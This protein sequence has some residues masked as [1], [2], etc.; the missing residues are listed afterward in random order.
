MVEQGCDRNWNIRDL[1]G[2]LMGAREEQPGARDIIWASEL[3]KPYIDRWLQMRGVPY[4]NPPEGKDLMAFF[5]GLQIEA[6][7]EQMLVRCGLAFRSQESVRIEIEDCLPVVGKADL[8]LEVRDWES[9]LALRE[10]D[11]LEGG[12][13][14]GHERGRRRALV[15]LLSRWQERCP[16]GLQATVF[17]VKSLNSAAF[18]YHR[19]SEGLSNAYPHHRL[20]LYTYLKGLGLDEGHLV[21]V[22]RDTGWM[23][24][25]V[26]R[27]TEELE[28]AW[29][30]DVQT[31][32][33][34][35]RTDERPPLEPKQIAGRDNWRVTYS[36]YRDYLY[37]EV[38][39][40]AFVF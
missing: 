35:V 31:I 38:Q 7:L 12:A 29:L 9:V 37:Q 33:R 15:G 30:E 4:S 32:S 24:E 5:L 18:R 16:K 26:I 8:V 3:G 27:G 13:Y 25:V 20:Q 6:G 14:A 17:E 19:G 11:L 22:A 1:L 39:H 21:Y 34:Y 23:E 36:R 40:G 2:D 10:M 28:R